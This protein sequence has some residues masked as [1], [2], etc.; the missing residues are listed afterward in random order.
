MRREVTRLGWRG[1]QP[2]REVVTCGS[3]RWSE[4]R[5]ARIPPGD[6]GGL[7]YVDYTKLVHV[8]AS[9]D[10]RPDPFPAAEVTPDRRSWIGSHAGT[11]INIKDGVEGVIRDG[12][13]YER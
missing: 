5:K 4:M 6:G 10:R 12:Q 9:V 11:S 1:A 13:I 8:S 7:A 3:S 2:A